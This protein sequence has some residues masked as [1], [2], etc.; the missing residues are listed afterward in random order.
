MADAVKAEHYRRRAKDLGLPVSSFVMGGYQ[1]YGRH[2]AEM[3]QPAAS[4]ELEG[5][6]GAATE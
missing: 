1:K 2:F 3:D 5:R 4:A 6:D